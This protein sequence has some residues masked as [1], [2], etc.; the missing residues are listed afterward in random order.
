MNVGDDNPIL[1][2]C[3]LEPSNLLFPIVWYLEVF[4]LRACSEIVDTS[5][6]APVAPSAFRRIVQ[7]QITGRRKVDRRKSWLWLGL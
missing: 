2:F 3:G 1:A 4:H 6:F 7:C 5:C